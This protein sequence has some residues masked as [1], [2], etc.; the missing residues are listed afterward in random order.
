MST[1][2]QYTPFYGGGQVANP[3]NVLGTSGAPSSVLTQDRLGTLSVD[4]ATGN[5]YGL[6]SKVGNVNTWVLL[7]GS[8]GAVA[9]VLG[10]ANQITATTLGN[11]V[12][13]SLP[14]AITAPGSLTTTTSLSATTTVTGGTG[15]TATTGNVAATVGS[16]TAGAAVSATTTVTGGTGVTAT[17]GNVSA[18]A[19]NVQATG[20]VIASKSAAGA[21]VTVQATNSDNTSGTSNAGVEIATGGASSGDPY[22]SFQISGVGASTMTMGLDNSASDIFVISN[23][24]SIGTSN[25]LTLTQAGALNATT[26]VTAGTSLT[27][28]LGDVTATNGNF[29]G[30]T[31]G[32]G[33]LLNSPATSGAASGPVIVN[34]R[35]G[36]ATFTSVSI[37]AAADLTLTITNSA[38]TGSST[39]VIYSMSGAT[40]GAALSIKSVTNTSGS[41]AI[42]VTNGT[43]ATTTTADIVINFLVLN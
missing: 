36:Q 35:S 41:S 12:T 7:G 39:Q 3:A 9:S 38:I 10:T 21:N 26:S 42:V 33:I 34:G 20:D 25:A 30:S 8:S 24:A 17:T 13:L 11:V 27:A 28:T 32:T 40:T 14:A 15:V 4:N 43:G 19:G 31:A 18:S 2:P 5:I 16:V 22:L 6:A 29:V 37:A 1:L 23:S